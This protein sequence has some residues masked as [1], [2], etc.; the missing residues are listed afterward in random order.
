MGRGRVWGV[1]GLAVLSVLAGVLLRSSALELDVFHAINA[2]GPLAPVWWSSWSV[3]GLGA[4]V[5]ILVAAGGAERAQALV[6]WLLVLVLGGLALHAVK[7]ALDGPRPLAVLGAEHMHVVGAALTRHAMPS[8]HSATGFALAAL[9]FFLGWRGW[10]FYVMAAFFVALSRL[11]VGA[12]W[13]SDA[14]VG[15]GLGLLSGLIGTQWPAAQ[16]LAAR[17]GRGLQSRVGSRLTAAAL[18]ALG[19]GFWVSD[20]DYPDALAV[21]AA[22]AV[23]GA[24]A[25]WRW[26][27]AHGAGWPPVATPLP[28][29]PGT[30][31]SDA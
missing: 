1:A 30:D 14:L 19:A 10:V 13:P 6:T 20:T 17:W 27:C 23:L 5:I 4:S 22:I 25:G 28:T 21:Q 11:A 7:F 24:W 2:W 16:R 12:H 3:A 15:S 26:W 8:G 18:V 31:R 9:A 29:A